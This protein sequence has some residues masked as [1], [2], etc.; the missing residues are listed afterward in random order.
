M[1]VH[2][3]SAAPSITSAP[4]SLAQDQ[5]RRIRVYSI[6]MGI[7]FAC[8]IGAYF[9]SGALQWVL[10]GAAIFLPYIAVVGSNMG[11][12]TTHT[13][14]NPM[15]WHQLD[16]PVVQSGDEDENTPPS[17]ESHD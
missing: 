3:R 11:R 6:Q 8:F 15:Q 1:W 17:K 13:M 7:R 16:A 14:D 2:R 9:A 10:I 4:T 12:L 5:G